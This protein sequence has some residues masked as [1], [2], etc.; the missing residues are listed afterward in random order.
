VV[1]APLRDSNEVEA[2]MS[3]WGREPNFG[4]IV[5]PDQRRAALK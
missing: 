2:A 5:V 3:Q 4:L 1:A